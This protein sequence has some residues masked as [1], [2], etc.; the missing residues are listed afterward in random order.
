[1][2]EG[3]TLTPG[4]FLAAW[5]SLWSKEMIAAPVCF[6]VAREYASGRLIG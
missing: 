6:A 1:L 3:S 5:R 4:S 2:L